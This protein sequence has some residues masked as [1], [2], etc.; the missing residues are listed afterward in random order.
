MSSVSKLICLRLEITEISLKL[1]ALPSNIMKY[2]YRI[3]CFQMQCKIQR[4][5]KTPFAQDC[6]MFTQGMLQFKQSYATLKT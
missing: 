5:E 4:K 6:T 1:I 3:P 2:H